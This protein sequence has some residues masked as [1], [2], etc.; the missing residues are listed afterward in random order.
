[1][2]FIGSICREMKWSFEEFLR[3]P[4][5]F[6]NTISLQIEADKKQQNLQNN[7]N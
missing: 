4:A 3:Q 2:L 5:W 6:V 1:M 7:Q